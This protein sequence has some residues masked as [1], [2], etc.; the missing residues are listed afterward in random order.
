MNGQLPCHSKLSGFNAFLVM[1]G[2]T[3]RGFVECPLDK[4]GVEFDTN[5]QVCQPS[6]PK[7]DASELEED[8]LRCPFIT[9]WGLFIAV[10]CQTAEG[11]G[12]KWPATMPFQVCTSATSQIVKCVNPA[13]GHD[14]SSQGI[15]GATCLC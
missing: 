5:R 6:P 11:L 2:A 10:C 8:T 7:E 3:N 12:V 1:E 14:L 9:A 13:P 15:L 4:F